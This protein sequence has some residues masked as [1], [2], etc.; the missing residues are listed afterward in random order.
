M[1]FEVASRNVGGRHAADLRNVDPEVPI[2]IIPRGFHDPANRP[3]ISYF[4]STTRQ[5]Q[6][7]GKIALVAVMRPSPSMLRIARWAAFF[8][9]ILAST[10]CSLPLPT[11]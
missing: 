5:R 10:A 4:R 1:I 7:G 6:Y 8:A 2:Q 9:G 3:R 11:G